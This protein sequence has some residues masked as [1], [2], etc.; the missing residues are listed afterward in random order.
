[1]PLSLFRTVLETPVFSR[2]R[3]NHGLEHATLHILAQRNPRLNM[4][5][6]STAAGFRIAGNISTEAL[7][8]AVTEAL[9]RLRAGEAQLAVHPNCGTNFVTAGMLSGLA[10]ASAMV[11]A[12]GRAR[13]KLERLPLA[14]ALATMALI[15]ALPLGMQV[16]RQVTTS[17]QPGDLQVTSIS[18]IA[19]GGV[20]IHFVQTQG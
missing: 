1:M 5:G 7:Q 15:A 19:R 11:G 4:A 13:D 16:Q 3:R 18:K 6:H 20:T 17:G 10:G 14:A 12:G 9:D 8:S 2:I